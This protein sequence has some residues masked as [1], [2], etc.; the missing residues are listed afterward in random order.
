M[1]QAK[2]KIEPLFHLTKRTD[3]PTW[4]AWV[5][6][7]AAIVAAFILSGVICAILTK[8][9]EFGGYYVEMING[10]FGTPRRILVLFNNWAIL[11]LIAVALAPAFKMK[12]WNIGAEGQVLVGALACVFIIK[13]FGGKVAEGGLIILM[14][15]A[16]MIL[17]G[18]WGVLPAI[19][20]ARWNTNETLF[21]LMMNY[22]ATQLVLFAINIWEPGGS[23]TIG[24]LDYGS[25]SPSLK[26]V[27][28]G[29]SNPEYIINAI[30]ITVITVAVFFYIKYSKHGYE[31]T[32][33]GESVNTAKYIGVNVRKTIIRTMLL[34]GV[35]CGIC[36]WFLV[37]GS[38]TPTVNA[39]LV[40]GRGF[41]AILVAWLGQL[42]PFIMMGTAFLV[43]FMQAGAAQSATA[44]NIGDSSAFSGVLI[45]VFF[46]IVIAAEFLVNYNVVFRHKEKKATKAKDDALSNLMGGVVDKHDE[47]QE[48]IITQEEFEEKLEEMGTE[49]FEQTISEAK[50]KE[51]EADDTFILAKEDKVVKENT[52]DKDI[53]NNEDKKE[54]D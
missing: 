50:Q 19:F 43:V 37:A 26:Q 32:V 30:L 36:G 5:I 33:V 12:F 6:R 28:V 44:F 48:D 47:A 9:Q 51:E 46:L 14:L 31:L 17:G 7:I 22:I 29:I 39:S 11:L 1:A 15:L 16:A 27:M 24:I 34:S 21:T 8:G 53:E 23:G 20:K 10:A 18:L 35:L 3:I 38:P 41:T 52:D 2:R 45:G 40:G 25:Y 54:D 49:F 4:K 13:H 42:N